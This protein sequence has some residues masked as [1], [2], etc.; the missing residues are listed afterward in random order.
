MKRYEFSITIAGY[1]ENADEA[2]EDACEG[3]SQD[4]GATPDE[5][6]Y[7]VEDEDEQLPEKPCQDGSIAVQ[8]PKG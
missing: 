3:F 7:T 2:W 1:G 5:G 8:N 4:A 6:E